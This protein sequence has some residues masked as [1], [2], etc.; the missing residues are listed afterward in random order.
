[1]LD[2]VII[3]D[4]PYTM[5][6]FEPY[7]LGSKS[8]PPA[9]KADVPAFLDT[10]VKSFLTVDV[11]GRVI[12]LDTYSKTLAPGARIGWFVANKMFIE[13]LL[14]GTEV[15]TQM[16]S[17]F[18]SV[19]GRIGLSDSRSL[20]ASSSRNGVWRDISSGSPTSASSTASA[21]TGW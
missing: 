10:M 17:G 4:D 3:E 14:R 18:S 5:L 9:A 15:Q 8:E 2:V 13:R 11:E 19:S 20:S 21:G 16:P 12:R 6:Q 1:M 7:V